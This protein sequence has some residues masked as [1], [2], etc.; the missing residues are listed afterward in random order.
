MTCLARIATRKNGNARSSFH[1]ALLLFV[2]RVLFSTWCLS[3]GKGPM[4]AINRSSIFFLLSIQI[5]L[6][7]LVRSLHVILTA[8]NQ[9]KSQGPIWKVLSAGIPCLLM[10]ISYGGLFE[11]IHVC[12]GPL[13]VSSFFLVLSH[14]SVECREN[15]ETNENNQLNVARHAFSCSMRFGPI[16]SVWCSCMRIMPSSYQILRCICFVRFSN[17]AT[18]W[19]GYH[20][21]LLL[22]SLLHPLSVLLWCLSLC[23]WATL[24]SH[25]RLQKRTSVVRRS[26][27]VSSMSPFLFDVAAVMTFPLSLRCCKRVHFIWSSALTILFSLVWRRS[28]RFCCL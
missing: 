13:M 14:W 4:C 11:L 5:H 16:W 27:F 23:S 1:S 8:R 18:E 10:A 7:D 9:Q 19:G 15:C 2:T 26:Y 22:G 25:R 21:H 20:L 24:N 6:C 17:M 28:C 12:H 3:T